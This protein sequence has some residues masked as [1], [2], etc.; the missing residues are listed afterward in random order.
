M[1]HAQYQ[2]NGPQHDT[3]QSGSIIIIAINIL[4]NKHQCAGK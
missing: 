2:T 3:I 4:D 1:I